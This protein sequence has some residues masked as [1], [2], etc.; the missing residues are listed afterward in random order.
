MSDSS[1]NCSTS[2]L[3][4]AACPLLVLLLL[5]ETC[6]HWLINLLV[7]FCCGTPPFPPQT[8]TKEL[9]PPSELVD[10]INQSEDMTVSE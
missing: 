7:A 9:K 5:S 2:F 6:L 4:P 10:A 8:R 3:C 1:P